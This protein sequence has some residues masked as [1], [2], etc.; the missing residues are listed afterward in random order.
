MR[1]SKLRKMCCSAIALSIAQCLVAFNHGIAAPRIDGS[2]ESANV[3]PN[4]ATLDE[5]LQAFGEKF[6]LKYHTSTAIEERKAGLYEGR[7]IEILKRLLVDYDHI[8]K[9]ENG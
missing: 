8:I 7:L 1:W 9:I 2:I 3:E 4:D 6:N 5:L